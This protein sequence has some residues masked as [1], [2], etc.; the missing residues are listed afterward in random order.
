MIKKPITLIVLDGWGYRTE[1]KDNAIAQANTPYFDKLWSIYPHTLLAASGEAVGLPDGQMGNSEVGHTTIGAGVIFDTDLVRIKRAIVSGEYKHNNA[2]ISVFEHARNNNSRLHI[3]GLLSDGGVHSHKDHLFE[4]LRVASLFGI[5][6]IAV[7]VFTDGRDVG[8]TSSV[9]YLRE[10]EDLLVDLGCGFIAT[11]SGRY[12]A[13]DRDNNWDRLDKTLKTIF[14]CEGA[15][16]EIKPS[17]FVASLHGAGISDEHI[18][19]TIIKQIGRDPVKIEQN[20]AIIFTNFRS[21]RARMISE[22]ILDKKLDMNLCF[23]TMTE[24]KNGFDAH[25]AFPV[26]NVETNLAEQVSKAGFSQAHIAE[27]EKFSHATYFLNCGKEEPYP[28]EIHILLDSRKDVA[29]HDLAPEMRALD[30][31]E[32]TVEMIESG[33]EFI[34]VNIANPDMVG[35]TANVPAIITAIETTDKALALI[36]ESTIKHGGVA[37]VTADHGNAEV[38]REEDGSLHIAHTCNLVPCIITDSTVSLKKEGTL[39]DLAPTVLDY[40][41][42]EKPK[43]MTGDSLKK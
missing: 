40:F 16:C 22:K 21:D 11:V 12:F 17:D 15:V 14:S 32:K 10:L 37:I 28:K 31:A 30:I 1:T 4:L 20:D 26:K 8:T 34:F 42:I 9:Q 24:Y 23:T 33:T 39:A 3:M 29:T 43:Q 27:T 5:K 13:M 35:H 19:P 38:N 7:H 18:E 36:V 41:G 6:D 2:F 25:V